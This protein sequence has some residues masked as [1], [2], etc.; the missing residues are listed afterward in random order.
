MLNNLIARYEII[1]YSLKERFKDT[2]HESPLLTKLV[3][4][5]DKELVNLEFSELDRRTEA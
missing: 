2:T 4:I 5:G 3:V 1:K